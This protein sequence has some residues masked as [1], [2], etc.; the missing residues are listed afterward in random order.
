MKLIAIYDGCR[1]GSFRVA[2]AEG[3]VGIQALKN[4]LAILPE[5]DRLRALAAIGNA[6]NPGKDTLVLPDTPANAYLKQVFDHL[7]AN[8]GDR[9]FGFEDIPGDADTKSAVKVE[10]K[11]LGLRES[12]AP[13]TFKLTQSAKSSLPK[14]IISLFS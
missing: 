5:T 12:V 14:L 9:E 2:I 7:L 4:A 10:M 13:L 11:S 8:C 1:E 6:E 3:I